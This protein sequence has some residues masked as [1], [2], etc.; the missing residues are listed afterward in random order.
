MADGK[1]V[2]QIIGDNSAF[3]K[4]IDETKNIAAQ[5][6][7]AV[8]DIGKTAMQGI[9]AGMA[10]AG[11]VAAAG[12]KEAVDASIEFESA[13]AGV[14]KT[15]NEVVD[16][17]G[18]V[19]YSYEMLSDAI[20]SLAT[21][22]PATTTEIA[23]VAEAAGQLGIQTENIM[24]FTETMIALG[25]STNLSSD[26]AA[27]SLA[28]F[29]N[30]VGMSQGD[31]DKLGSSI[32]AL[33]NN[34]ATTEADIVNMAMRLAGAGETV[35]LTEAEILG[36]AT[37][38][39]S[40]GIEAEMGGSAFSK[41]MV[42]M[43]VAA[44]TGTNAN[45]VIAKTGMSLREL[46]LFADQDAKG[47]K[48]LANSMGM[49]SGELKSLMGN[50]EDMQNFAAVMGMTGSQFSKAFE[51]DAVGAINTFING[52]ATAEERGTS[53]IAVLDS[54]GIT[55]VRLRDALLRAAN[56]GDLLSDA[57]AL[58]TEAWEE[59]T[60]L[61]NEAGQRYAT[62]ES[63][64]AML[65]NAVN[66]LGITVGDSLNGTLLDG[67]DIA[68]DW[69]AQLSA[70]FET[71][72]LSGAV[73]SLGGIFADAVGIIMESAP[74][75]IEAVSGLILQL[76]GALTDNMPQLLDAG[77]ML[78]ENLVTGFHEALPMISEIVQQIAPLLVEGFIQYEGMIMEVGLTILTALVQGIA[79]NIDQITA[80]ATTVLENLVLSLT[81][82][83]PL[84]IQGAIDIIIG[85]GNFLAENAPMLIDAATQLITAL[86][87]LI[88]ENL[89]PIIECAV[90]ILMAI[91]NGLIENLPELVTAAVDLINYLVI[92]LV[93]NAPLLL[94]SA[95]QL[96][97]QL[98][99]GLIECLPSLAEQI[100][101]LVLAIVDAI[102]ANAPQ[103]L[104]AA[105]Q[106]IAQLV[107]GL[108]AA[109]MQ[110]IQSGGELVM[111]LIDGLWERFGSLEGDIRLIVTKIVEAVSDFVSDFISVGGDLMQ[112]LING[113]KAKIEA[114]V[115]AIKEAVGKIVDAA[116]GLLGIESPSKVFKYIGQMTDEGLA[117]GVN[118]YA[119]IPLKAV[120]K[121]TT[122]VIGTAKINIPDM[123]A[124]ETG[125]NFVHDAQSTITVQNVMSG[126][127]EVDGYTLANIVL[128]NLDDAGAFTLRGA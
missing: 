42:N 91:C 12:I 60:A 59:N 64:I 128:R 84:L 97:A 90:A 88:G 121:L 71:G 63:Q 33:G 40:V 111:K 10:A 27:S 50:A 99:M 100:P 41:L 83:L 114:G 101:M 85:L 1:V 119:D 15:V 4:T 18:N 94:D 77:Y 19:T 68:R 53:A 105:A 35:G 67:I 124:L 20:R 117:V 75:I 74:G 26:E 123:H 102:I 46:Q 57:V 87:G 38:L 5:G 17:N 58:G 113:I 126:T 48:A 45:S 65:K 103:L 86:V 37:A 22:I 43:K 115:K 107:L 118:D 127:L 39:S 106:I 55:E 52:L 2:Y 72:G 109:G 66:D 23:G 112:G 122:D 96:I 73:E 56:A 82:N 78:L 79:E 81:E 62:T 89:D 61:A 110:L 7:G 44:E 16:E 125:L 28:Q 120:R 9:A 98:A 14:K 54:M 116:K 95:A 34:F 25:E 104:S 76:L 36:V 29:A 24:G 93:E 30:I 51:Q 108:A 6:L 92:A 47:F 80:S 3:Q 13:F 11:T 70:G 21:E 49:T 32:V 31:F 69:I 8:S